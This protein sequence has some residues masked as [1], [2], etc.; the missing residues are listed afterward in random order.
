MDARFKDGLCREHVADAGGDERIGMERRQVAGVDSGDNRL[1]GSFAEGVGYEFQFAQVVGFADFHEGLHVMALGALGHLHELFVVQNAGNQEHRV[2]AA[3]VG[4]VDFF[5]EQQKVLAQHSAGVQP[6]LGAFFHGV[7]HG[8]QVAERALEKVPFG[9]YR[10]GLRVS[11]GV[12]AG[13]PDG[14]Q[15]GC[16]VALRGRCPLDFEDGARRPEEFDVAATALFGNVDAEIQSKALDI[17]TAHAHDFCKNV[18]AHLFSFG[19]VSWRGKFRNKSPFLASGMAENVPK[20][21][22]CGH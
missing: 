8:N 13:E 17:F 19:N 4:D 1:R 14:V 7:G 12:G 20:M 22:Y 21:L 18:F 3:A 16:D 6:L 15:V 2:G 10:D 11:V 9:Q 5:F